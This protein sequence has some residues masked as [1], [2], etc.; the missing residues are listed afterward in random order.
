MRSET[1]NL[2]I[3]AESKVIK[4]PVDFVTKDIS[5]RAKTS[6]SVNWNNIP[7][8]GA[9]G[10][11]GVNQQTPDLSAIIQE[12]VSDAK[13]TAGDP[14]AFIIEGTGERVARAY[15]WASENGQNVAP[16]LH[17]EYTTNELVIPISSSHDDARE[18]S[19]TDYCDNG[20]NADYVRLKQS[21]LKL[22]ED[23]DEPI[24]LRFQNVTIPRGT[25]IANAYLEFFP[26]SYDSGYTEYVIKRQAAD[27][28]TE[29]SDTNDNISDRPR[30]GQ[31]VTWVV[32]DVW[33]D[34]DVRYSPDIS[35]VIQEIIG[36][37]GWNEGNSLVLVIGAPA[38]L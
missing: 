17:I 37:S 7:Q 6:A 19:C 26:S 36:R 25:I 38:D 15:R 27:N 13:W 1:T 24:G 11:T 31:G 28:P 16:L 35:A 5:S 4:S 33:Q 20:Q 10:E 30:T 23:L 32:T 14:I 8:W 22:P 21:S 3:W 2:T 18:A 34:G 9:V 29:F 12:L